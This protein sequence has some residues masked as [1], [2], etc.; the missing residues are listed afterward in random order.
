MQVE[1]TC[2]F[3]ICAKNYL[4]LA[5]TLRESYLRHN[6]E[7][8][9]YIF[10]SDKFNAPVQLDSNVLISKEVL[11]ISDDKWINMSFKYEITEFCTSIKPF[12]FDYLFK[13]KSFEK[14]VYLD[15]D[16]FV[17]SDFS[18][19]YDN[20]NTSLFITTPHILSLLT[21]DIE[22]LSETGDS[23]F[24]RVGINNFGFVAIRKSVKSLKIV[25]WWKYKLE[26]H[27][28]NERLNA[29]FTDQKWME[30]LPAFLDQNEYLCTKNKGINLAPWNYFERKITIE[31]SVVF[32]EDRID[33][34]NL[35]KDPLVLAHFAGYK[36]KELFKGNFEKRLR[37]Q[38][39]RQYE[40]IS[41]IL[42]TY[43]LALQKN[44]DIFNKY[45]N[46]TYTYNTYENGVQIDIPQRRIYNSLHIN[47]KYN[48]NPF[49]VN[50]KSNSYFSLLKS[51][52]L[53]N[54]SGK[55]KVD[56]MS[57]NDLKGYNKKIGLLFILMR[58]F[59]RVIGYKYYMLYLRL[60]RHLCKYEN[61]SFLLGKAYSKNQDF[62]S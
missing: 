23:T 60:M 14:V 27:C 7:S 6:K 25:D 56:K 10:I 43:V 2:A 49:I 53:I 50:N 51:H 36:Y 31:N 4:G 1:K 29:T 48:I 57:P 12:C 3:T 34:Q 30:Y 28:F 62:G 26:N 45:I 59:L 44:K 21:P 17:F 33:S 37:V 47:Y 32:V 20:L 54:F 35:R 42:S 38:G 24:L 9:F 61:Q 52:K 39:L 11:E 41:N 19:V 15:P 40:D 13:H 8:D 5:F 58:L 18:Y 16:T 55:I 46:L 22:S